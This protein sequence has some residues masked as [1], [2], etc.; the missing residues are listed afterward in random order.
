MMNCPIC[1]GRL[2]VT[3]HM[4]GHPWT[5]AQDALALR[6]ADLDVPCERIAQLLDSENG[7]GP[8]ADRITRLRHRRKVGK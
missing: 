7:A 2:D 6:L 5:P 4:A 3:P 8:V 1:A